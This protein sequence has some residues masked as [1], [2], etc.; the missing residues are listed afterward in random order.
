MVR[1]QP[2]ELSIPLSKQDAKGAPGGRPSF[3]L[4]LPGLAGREETLFRELGGVRV[5]GPMGVEI[6]LRR[7]AVR[8][9]GLRLHEHGRHAG[10][11]CLREAVWRIRAT[12]GTT[13]GAA[14]VSA[15]LANVVS[16]DGSSGV[17]SAGCENT[18]E[19]GAR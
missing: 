8:V 16:F 13:P 15:F 4:V 5:A 14:F 12:A 6:P 9:T 1:V 3:Y 19:S 17:P 2:G 11:G 10:G 18:I 7:R